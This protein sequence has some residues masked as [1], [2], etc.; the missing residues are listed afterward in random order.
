MYLINSNDKFFL[1]SLGSILRQ[2]NFPVSNDIKNNHYGEIKFD[3]LKNKII[4]EFEKKNFSL[5]SPFSFNTLWKNILFLMK[6][7]KINFDTLS[8]FPTQETLS[9][10]DKKLKL[11]YTHNQIIRQALQS[12]GS[13]IS[14]VD[15]YKSIWPKDIDIHINK[16]DTHL[17]N[18]KNLLKENFN[19]DFLFKSQSSQITFLIN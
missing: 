18:L 10:K 2:K 17:T 13:P 11:R 4:I 19:Y 8:Y 7:N 12:R 3:I 15:L 9:I 14:K 16:L 1:K 6:D 5:K